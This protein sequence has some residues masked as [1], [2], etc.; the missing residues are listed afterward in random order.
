MTPQQRQAFKDFQQANEN[1]LSFLI[2]RLNTKDFCEF[3]R[4]RRLA[5]KTEKRFGEV[6]KNDSIGVFPQ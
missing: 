4:L 2:K 1:L 6:A 3:N 5:D